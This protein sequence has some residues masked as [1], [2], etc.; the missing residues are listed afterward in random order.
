MHFLHINFLLD[1]NLEN[2]KLIPTSVTFV[3]QTLYELR[4][5]K[6]IEMSLNLIGAS[7]LGGE[8]A[9]CGLS[10]PIGSE[11]KKKALIIFIQMDKKM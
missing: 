7:S 11:N 6:L 5:Y 1:K 9:R 3:F 2:G 8:A 4:T 10:M